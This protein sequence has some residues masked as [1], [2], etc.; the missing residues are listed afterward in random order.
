[1]KK[2]PSHCRANV[3]RTGSFFKLHRQLLI[4]RVQELAPV[5]DEVYVSAFPVLG[6]GAR[7][8]AKGVDKTVRLLLLNNLQRIEV[9]QLR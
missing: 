9:F 7:I 6:Q 8:A 2:R 5:L 3:I 4:E 1:M